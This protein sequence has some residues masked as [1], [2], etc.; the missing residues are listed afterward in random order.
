MFV[1]GKLSVKYFERGSNCKKDL[2]MSDSVP[3][4]C[5]RSDNPYSDDDTSLRIMTTTPSSTSSGSDSSVADLSAESMAALHGPALRHIAS[6]FT[7][8][9]SPFVLNEAP[10]P[11]ESTETTLI[12]SKQKLVP[13]RP[14]DDDVNYYDD[15]GDDRYYVYDDYV[16][17]Y[18]FQDDDVYTFNDDFNYEDDI[19]NPPPSVSTTAFPTTTS[20]VYASVKVRCQ[21]APKRRTVSFNVVQVFFFFFL[22]SVWNA[23]FLQ[24]CDIY[25]FI[26]KICFR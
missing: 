26:S 7:S 20:E 12:T 1:D 4:T 6:L 13:R 16:Y 2:F 11:A 9:T 15:D 10:S 17:I 23:I 22:S 3:S 24:L 18:P 19:L 8:G 25:Y 21:T 5:Q 14:T